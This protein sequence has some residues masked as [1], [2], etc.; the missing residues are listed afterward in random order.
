MWCGYE[1]N[2]WELKVHN[3]P[4]QYGT[5]YIDLKVVRVKSAL[6]GTVLNKLG[7]NLVGALRNDIGVIQFPRTSGQF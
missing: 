7:S 6:G 3:R 1:V 5:P 4:I 2:T